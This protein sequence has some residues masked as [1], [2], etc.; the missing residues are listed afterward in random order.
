MRQ[1][2]IEINVPWWV[3]TEISESMGIKFDLHRNLNCGGMESIFT[4]TEISDSMG[5]KSVATEDFS[6]STVGL[7]RN[8]MI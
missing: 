8:T 7:E 1:F 4:S 6:N 3:Y 2:L 5:I